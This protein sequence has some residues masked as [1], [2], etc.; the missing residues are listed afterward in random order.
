MRSR[1]G[2]GKSFI[3]FLFL[4]TLVLAGC[5]GGG[6]DSTPPPP[7]VV[8]DINGSASGSGATGSVFVID[9]NNL[10][11]PS[12]VDFRDA[13][14]N[15]VVAHATID[16]AANIYIKATV[17]TSGLTTTTYKVTVTTPGGTSNAE[18]FLVLPS[19]SFSPSA[20]NWAVTYSLPQA[21]T[22]F[23]T[24]IS[25]ITSSATISSSATTTNYIYAIGGNLSSSST[26]SKGSNTATVYSNVINDANGALLYSGWT[27]SVTLLPEARSFTASVSANKFN[28]QVSK[29]GTIYV[30][31]GLD[32]SGNAADTV[33][34]ASL[35]GDG[36]IPDASS[37]G[38]WTAT[39]RLPKAL[40]AEGAAIYHGYIYIAGGNDSSGAPVA[41]VYYAKINRD[42]TLGSWA[43]LSSLPAARAYHQLLAVAGALYVIGGD[44]G[45]VDPLSNTASSSTGL[46]SVLYSQIN[47][48]DGTLSAWT[49]SN[50]LGKYREKHTAVVAGGYIV[51]TGGL[52]N[53]SAGSSESEYASISADGSLT[54][55]NGATG[56]NTISSLSSYNPFN[57]S[58][59]FFADSS[60]NPHIY[61]LGGQD[62]TSGNPSSGCWF[63]Y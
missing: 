6:G 47:I 31:G 9:G 2:I 50:G 45:S 56:T 4:F 40:F 19:V 28:S 20:I 55:F 8:N 13:T 16:F 62:V 34:Y 21:Q 26:D 54:P 36:T 29:N 63:Q 39:T 58:S 24:V 27:S 41:D 38:T 60:G 22:G 5:G 59:V 51:V 3:V 53:G 7:P 37:A 15:A 43:T 49:S 17:P 33:Y 52:Y 61:I 11:N 42:G 32:G 25:S 14:T 10:S 23:S 1:I 44:S 12:S 18:D 48:A 46:S 35:N 57:Q 30:I